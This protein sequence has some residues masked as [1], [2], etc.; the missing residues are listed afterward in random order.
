[1]FFIVFFLPQNYI[2]LIYKYLT[3]IKLLFILHLKKSFSHYNF[4]ER[5]LIFAERRFNIKKKWF[6]TLKK[7]VF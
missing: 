1:M 5:K 6:F 2:H 4:T 7:V 3:T